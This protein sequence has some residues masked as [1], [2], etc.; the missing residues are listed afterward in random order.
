MAIVLGS[1][2]PSTSRTTVLTMVAVITPRPSPMRVTVI[3]VASAAKEVFTRLFPRSMVGSTL[4]GWSTIPATRSAPCA[5]LSTRPLILTFRS[6]RRAAS[7]LE[8]K[9]DS[10]RDGTRRMR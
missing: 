3:T 8:K 5:P 7:E 4:A 6:D 10:R 2:S 9:A 1:V